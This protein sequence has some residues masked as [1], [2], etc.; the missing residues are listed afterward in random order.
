MGKLTYSV[1]ASLDLYVEDADGHFAW[2]EPD[3]EMLAVVN[4]LERPVGTYLYGRRMYDT[5]K[6]WESPTGMDDSP[7]SVAFAGIWQAAEKVVYSKTLQAPET[8]R[9]RIDTEFDPA[10]VRALKE[11]TPH[12][13][14]IGG[15]ELAGL[16]LAAGLVDEVNLLLH[17]IAVGGGK[18]VFPTGLRV[19]LALLDQRRFDSGAI[20]LHYTV[21][22]TA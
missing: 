4:D 6:F 22:P 3:E 16:A 9:T 19:D 5:M 10:A 2:A 15:A 11:Q 13:L 7:G 20:H 12:E 1:I 21:K 8:P 14:S 17:P 18:P